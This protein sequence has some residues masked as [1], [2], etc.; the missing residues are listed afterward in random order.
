M[1]I[2]K[3]RGKFRARI[4]DHG[5]R[6]NVGLFDTERKAKLALTRWKKKNDF[7]ELWSEKNALGGFED[8]LPRKNRKIRKANLYDKSKITIQ[9]GKTWLKERLGR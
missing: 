2:T 8:I 3:E 5:K 9:K 1:G 4:N 7:T 6:I